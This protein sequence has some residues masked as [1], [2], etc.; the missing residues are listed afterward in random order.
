MDL[1]FNN[2][3][4]AIS[5][6]GLDKNNI[7]SILRMIIQDPSKDDFIGFLE[8]F[9][10][11]KEE[12][13]HEICEAH[14]QDLLNS[15]E[16][17]NQM[18]DAF[19]SSREDVGYL[20]SGIQEIGNFLIEV[21]GQIEQ[22]KKL[23]EDLQSASEYLEEISAAVFLLN[24][25]QQQIL[26]LRH[27]S[28]LRTLSKAKSLK[29]LKDITTET[30]KIILNI[31]PSMEKQIEDKIKESLSDW[32]V[33]TR[34]KAELLGKQMF[35]Q[36][37]GRLALDKQM[38]SKETQK[39]YKIRESAIMAIPT[40]KSIR[41]SVKPS[42]ELNSYMMSK[43]VSMRQSSRA[44]HQT[45]A[46]SS[47]I[48]MITVDFSALLQYENV[49]EALGKGKEFREEMKYNRRQQIIQT[50]SFYDK[51][52]EKLE[53]LAGQ[54]LIEKELFEHDDRLRSEEEIQG[55]WIETI[56]QLERILQESITSACQA[57]LILDI[58]K[59]TVLFVNSTLKSKFTHRSYELFQL[60][61]KNHKLYRD[62]LLSNFK[63]E[64]M[65]IIE[66]ENYSFLHS[67]DLEG[68]SLETIGLN[69]ETNAGSFP[70]CKSVPDLA[71]LVKKYVWMDLAYLEYIFERTGEELFRTIDELMQAVNKLL[72]HR[73]NES[74]VLQTAILAINTNY[75]YKS[76]SFLYE[77]FE[78]VTGASREF[79]AREVFIEL[80]DKCESAIFSKMQESI[81]TY[82]N[83]IK[84]F[85]PMT[86]EAHHWIRDMLNYI[87]NT[88]GSLES[89]LGLQLSSTALYASFQYISSRF[90]NSLKKTDQKFNIFFV[91]ILDK[92]LNI[93]TL[94]MQESQFCRKV[95]GISD[96]LAEIR[97]FVNLFMNDDLE[98][99]KDLK[100]REKKYSR[101]E[102][103][104]LPAVLEKFVETKG[105]GPK[106]KVVLAVAKKLKEII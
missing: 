37:E 48:T 13:I 18:R 34:K 89:L 63:L 55:L 49:F 9:I 96:A 45:S 101:L 95:P 87:N 33:K 106:K 6:Y 68:I 100:A 94:F 41:P 28:A 57:N 10:E 21:H 69:M 24:K 60:L 15:L 25:A 17:V 42:R 77:H 7:P 16:L 70:F 86:V 102:I 47:E 39:G 71:L 46:D 99:L 27:I 53:A 93:I 51:P 61:D 79:S 54:L 32:L 66:A 11:E 88:A 72:F 14:S 67:N 65:K 59:S 84:E 43:L 91:M 85:A 90:F 52:R 58:K 23:V 3:R 22:P 5:R 83:M 50:T 103:K 12:E 98:C 20:Q 30:S 82:F 64:A 1:K 35:V 104:A 97:E 8:E 80:K 76:F 2:L 62:S 73:I 56:T 26:G 19:K 92:D 36:A 75:L 78:E 81:C 31:I 44:S 40:M 4:S 29:I 38:K 74:T 105:K